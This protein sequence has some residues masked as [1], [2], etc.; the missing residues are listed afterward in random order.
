MFLGNLLLKQCA[1][2]YTITTGLVFNIPS[3]GM[4][5]KE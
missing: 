4:A 1:I 5:G 2:H 3:A